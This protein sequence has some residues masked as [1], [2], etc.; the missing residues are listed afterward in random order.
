MAK[1]KTPLKNSEAV[2]VRARTPLLAGQRRP[3]ISFRLPTKMAK[4]VEHCQEKGAAGADYPTLSRRFGPQAPTPLLFLG[5]V[6]LGADQHFRY[7]SRSDEWMTAHRAYRK[8]VELPGFRQNDD[9]R[10]ERERH[11]LK[12]CHAP[13]DYEAVTRICGDVSKLQL[14]EE[15]MLGWVPPQGGKWL[16]WQT[17]EGRLRTT[18]KGLEFL[19]NRK[20]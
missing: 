18:D 10:A 20:H 12:L 15:E 14:L 7:A 9:L 4:A 11:V 1:V 19:A 17:G 3:G 2:A 13:K 16:A 6:E 5:F 8:A